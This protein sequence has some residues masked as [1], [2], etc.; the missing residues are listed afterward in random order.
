MNGTTTAIRATRLSLGDTL[1]RQLLPFAFSIILARL[2]AP[3][4]FGVLAMLYIFVGLASALAEGGLGAALIQKQRTSQTEETSVFVF[5]AGTGLAMTVLL[6]L[7]ASAIERFYGH[8]G[9]AAIAMAMAANVLINALGAIHASLAVRALRMGLLLRIGL[10]AN[11]SSGLVALG[12]AV[13]GFGAW[14]L[15]A[16]AL[17]ASTVQTLLLWKWHDWRPRGRFSARELAPLLR[18]GGP[19]LAAGVL[20]LLAGRFYTLLIGRLHGAA[21]LG[22]YMRAVT[23]QNLPQ[24]LVAGVMR[25]VAFPLLSA[26]KSDI[27]LV[28]D[29]ARTALRN[30]MLLQTPVL[31]GIAA[32]AE[33]LVPFLFGRAWIDSVPILQVLCIAGCVYPVSV[34]NLTAIKALGHSGMFLKLEVMKKTVLLSLL[35]IAAP[36]GLLAIAWSQAVSALVAC[37]WNARQGRRLVGYAIA[38]QA[39][40]AAPSL[41]LGAAM[42]LAVWLSGRLMGLPDGMTLAVQVPLGI[43]LY[44]AGCLAFGLARWDDLR[45]YLGIAR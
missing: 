22:L 21:P 29:R 5:N 39:R 9:L 12:M 31:L 32:T 30:A 23:T 16:Q 28:R 37:A 41:A 19:L 7:S 44:A 13:N 27:A 3:A 35:F 15:V 33:W 24:A 18:Y 2:L 11:V 26:G 1:L 36:F 6:C 20:D 38:M 45:G 40:D 34:V 4:E 8:P 25:Q 17:V 10:V 43:A 14:S 42:G